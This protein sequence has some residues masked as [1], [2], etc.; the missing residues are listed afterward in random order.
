MKVSNIYP[1]MISHWKTEYKN[2]YFT[3]FINYFLKLSVFIK[4][5]KVNLSMC[6]IYFTF[7]ML[8]LSLFLIV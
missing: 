1:Y 7:V 8:I 5:V 2:Y 3:I 4:T 6:V